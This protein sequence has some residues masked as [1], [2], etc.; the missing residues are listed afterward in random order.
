MAARFPNR[1]GGRADTVYS[2]GKIA[3]YTGQVAWMILNGLDP[4]LLEM[5]EEQANE[6]LMKKAQMMR[7]AGVP[8]MIIGIR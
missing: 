4:K 5:D 3:A 8:T 1:V 2:Y 6:S 7:W